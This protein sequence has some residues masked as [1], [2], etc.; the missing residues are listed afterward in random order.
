LGLKEIYSHIDS[1]PLLKQYF[2]DLSKERARMPKQWIVNM[3]ATLT[4]DGFELWVKD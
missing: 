1:D 4:G 2:P 3:L